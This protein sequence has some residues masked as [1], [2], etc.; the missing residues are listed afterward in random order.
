MTHKPN[1]ARLVAVHSFPSVCRSSFSI[2]S[3]PAHR[4]LSL[5]CDSPAW[6]VALL[7]GQRISI[8]ARL[9]PGANGTKGG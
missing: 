7:Q 5:S 9:R 2:L 1:S 3:H 4:Q 8:I 6:Y